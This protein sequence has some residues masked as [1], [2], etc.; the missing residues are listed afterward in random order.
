MLVVPSWGLVA[1]GARGRFLRREWCGQ[2]N[3]CLGFRLWGNM[4]EG[5]SKRQDTRSPKWRL[6]QQTR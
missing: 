1:Q 5:L 6:F 4:T 2:Y 3:V